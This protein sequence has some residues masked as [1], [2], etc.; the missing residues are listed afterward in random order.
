MRGFRNVTHIGSRQV[1]PNKYK[2]K[3]TQVDGIVFDSAKEAR[4]Y[5]ELCMLFKAG[6]IR[7]IE[8]QPTYKLKCGGVPIKIRD[9][10]GRGRQ[11]VTKLDFRYWDNTRSCTVVEDV[12]GMDTP[13][14]R[15]KRAILEAEYGVHVV[16]I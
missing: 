12:K 2:N 4:R 14:S 15:L 5:R 8:L 10:N 11:S 16:C 9:K 6:K 1:A 3:K 7:E 13:V